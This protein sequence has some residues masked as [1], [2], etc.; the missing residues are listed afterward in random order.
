MAASA[1]TAA[2]LV[3]RLYGSRSPVGASADA[4][5]ATATASSITQNARTITRRNEWDIG[6]SS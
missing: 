5:G 4:S 6:F 3:G 2:L 1:A